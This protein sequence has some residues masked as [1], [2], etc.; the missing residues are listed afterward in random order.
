LALQIVE[1]LVNFALLMIE[2]VILTVRA[3]IS[4]VLL[5]CT[6]GLS[7]SG[8]VA[9]VHLDVFFLQAFFKVFETLDAG[10]FFF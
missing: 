7:Y 5:P 3:L 4:R 9:T 6:Q 2:P 10:L 8:R 1:R